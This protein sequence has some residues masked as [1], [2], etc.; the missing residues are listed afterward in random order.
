[1]NFQ[2]RTSNVELPMKNLLCFYIQ[3]SMLSV[4]CSTFIFFCHPVHVFNRATY[5]HHTIETRTVKPFLLC[6]LEGGGGNPSVTTMARLY[7]MD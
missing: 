7:K 5:I 1:M 4:E 6:L 2:H 3:H